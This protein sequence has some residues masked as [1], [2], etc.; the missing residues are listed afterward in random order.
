VYRSIAE[1]REILDKGLTD[2]DVRYHFLMRKASDKFSRAVQSLLTS[3]RLIRTYDKGDRRRSVLRLSAA[4]HAVYTR[5]APLA[6]EYERNL[7]CALT[8][9]ERR[10]LDRLISVLLE[11]AQRME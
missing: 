5:V 6:L 10:A 1:Y 9:A 3:R 2:K 7:L 4:G 8:A 11:R